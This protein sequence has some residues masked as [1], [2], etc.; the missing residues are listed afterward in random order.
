MKELRDVLDYAHKQFTLNPIG[1]HD[2]CDPDTS[3]NFSAMP[4]NDEVIPSQT[5]GE[6]NTLTGK[7]STIKSFL[8]RYLLANPALRVS[9]IFQL[10]VSQKRVYMI[11]NAKVVTQVYS[12]KLRGEIIAGLGTVIEKLQDY[13][14]R[15]QNKTLRLCFSNEQ[16][17]WTIYTKVFGN[18]VFSSQVVRKVYFSSLKAIDFR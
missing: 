12:S 16:E 7:D 10:H 9:S 13:Q 11:E 3:H 1:A 5:L 6:L 17:L 18:E 4:L 15:Y 14:E 2:F 8:K